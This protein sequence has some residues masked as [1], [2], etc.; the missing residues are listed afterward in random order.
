MAEEGTRVAAIARDEVLS[1]V[2]MVVAVAPC[3]GCAIIF[4]VRMAVVMNR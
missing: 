1:Q 3:H 4:L 2:V